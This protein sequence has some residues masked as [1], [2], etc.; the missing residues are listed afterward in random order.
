MILLGL[1]HISKTL[2][3]KK[4]LD[5]VNLHIDTGTIVC[6][7]G[8]SG[9]GKTTLLRIIAGLERPDSGT[10]T[11]KGRDITNLEPHRRR[12]GMMFQDFALFP[13]MDVLQ[14]VSF[15]PRMQGMGKK[16]AIARAEQALKTVGLTAHLNRKVQELSGGER[17]RVALARTI[18]CS[19]RL[20][21]LDEPL[22]SLD[23][24]LREHLMKE[25]RSILKG[26]NATCIFVTHDHS[27][28]YAVSDL[29]AVMFEGHIVQVDPPRHLYR[30]PVSSRVARFLGLS[31]I[32]DGRLIDDKIIESPIGAFRPNIFLSGGKR[33]VKVLIQPDAARIAEGDH[34]AGEGTLVV[35]GTVRSRL[36]RGTHFD[37][38]IETSQGVVL[39]FAMDDHMSDIHEGAPITL[40][41]DPTKITLLSE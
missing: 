31:N 6:L 13:H 9:C 1:E 35:G 22:G 36:Y 16:G 2:G 8:P 11:L 41:V 40:A 18:A 37:V 29:T 38:E 32:L 24:A 27:E 15:G 33:D 10:I 34:S 30:R 14:N 20:Y 39:S 26:I 7:L 21:L 12:F 4:V 28:A 3:G 5:G 23:R 17:Q 19:P 25:L